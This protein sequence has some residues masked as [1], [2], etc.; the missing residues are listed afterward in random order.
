MSNPKLNITDWQKGEPEHVPPREPSSLNHR[1]WH[2]VLG[3]VVT[4]AL[5]TVLIQTLVFGNQVSKVRPPEVQGPGAAF[6]KSGSESTEPLVLIQ[7]S[8]IDVR[9]KALAEDLA[10]MG[11]ALK[12]QMV[13]I[14]SP[15]A[16][17]HID[18]AK[19]EI[20]DSSDPVA[21]VDQ[22]DPAARAALFGRYTGQIDA[23]IERAWKRPRSPINPID[24]SQQDK[25]APSVHE[26]TNEANT[27]RCQVRILQDHRGA[28][29]EVQV[30]DCNG[31]V[32][33]QQSLVRAILSASPLPAPPSATVFS[34]A[35]DM[36]FESHAYTA[37]SVADDFELARR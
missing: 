31:S 14:L 25:N 6:I 16:L 27:F 30:I 20:G 37:S 34:H 7:L 28:V 29:Q 11:S 8:A 1:S 17:P 18:I 24:E 32:E 13:A 26:G 21:S 35:L 5:H 3:L 10:S 19:D 23:R 12:D 4:V 15:D 2:R 33:W 36:R 9:N 22:G